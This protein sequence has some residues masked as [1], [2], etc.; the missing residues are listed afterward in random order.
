MMNLL[1]DI[2]NTRLKWALCQ[3]RHIVLSQTFEH[4]NQ[5]IT[6]A[7]LLAWKKICAPHR[8]VLACVGLETLAAEV[9][10]V[11][12]QLWPSAVLTRVRA[13]AFGH[14]VEN[15]YPKPE[16][17]GVDRWLCL[18]AARKHFTLPVCIVDCGTAI[19]IDVLN[20]GGGHRGGLIAPGLRLMGSAL[21]QGT[22]NLQHFEQSCTG[23]LTDNTEAAIANG[24]LLAAAGLIERVLSDQDKSIKLVL[25][26][27]DASLIARHLN[28]PLTI[29]PE[30][31]FQGLM[32]F[33]DNS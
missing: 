22:Y 20:A 30:L 6:P 12:G 16:K 14:G 2:G 8:I 27:G 9:V 31:L 21:L 15:A 17:L 10:S 23:S 25:T 1:I 4:D 26:G 7:L 18:I 32:V 33:L 28:R 13:Q 5:S 3:D 19:T 29:E 11:S 24:A